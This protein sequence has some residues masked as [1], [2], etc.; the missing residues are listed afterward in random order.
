MTGKYQLVIFDLDGVLADTESSWGYVHNHFGET[1]EA[2]VKAYFNGE[3]DDH[4]FMRR[5]IAIWKS[6]K[7][8]LTI[9]DIS[10]ILSEI[11]L[12][13]GAEETLK[14]LR[15][16]GL[17][18]VIIS[19]GLKPLAAR[20]AEIVEFDFVYANGLGSDGSGKLS[21][22]G[23]LNVPLMDKEWVFHKILNEL[24]I[25]AEKSVAVG[26]STVDAGML[27]LAGLGIA[28]CPIDDTVINNADIVVK[29]KNLKE[30]MRFII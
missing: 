3:I 11:P 5:D 23:I 27:K 21:D 18:L 4:E 16:K 1:N 9:S 19:G 2:N 7:P 13:P 10:E 15:D 12:M 25:P 14:E 29:E 20:V 28:F 26:D 30:I 8:D 22:E 17:K 24:A 6:H